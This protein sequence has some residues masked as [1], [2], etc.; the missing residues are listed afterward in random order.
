LSVNQADYRVGE[1][2]E[3]VVSYASPIDQPIEALWL[4]RLHESA[5]AEPIDAVNISLDAP[6]VS[7]LVVTIGPDL[8]P[9]VYQLKSQ[10]P[11]DDPEPTI[12][13]VLA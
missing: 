2:I 1:P 6:G 8:S 7:N 13:R 3:I 9:G 5:P 4:E 12:F 11:T 10:R